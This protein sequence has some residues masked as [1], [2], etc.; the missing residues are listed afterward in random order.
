MYDWPIGVN[1]RDDREGKIAAA[2]QIEEVRKKENRM[3]V[4]CAYE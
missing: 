2:K 4:V 1:A 3:N